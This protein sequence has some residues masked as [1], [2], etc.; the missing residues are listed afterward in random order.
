MAE[1]PTLVDKLFKP[2]DTVQASTNGT[3]AEEDEESDDEGAA[4]LADALKADETAAAKRDTDMNLV[5]KLVNP[6]TSGHGTAH[7][8]SG[9]G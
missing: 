4:W 9:H 5:M 1:Y 2:K 8:T 7:R 6:K 3:N